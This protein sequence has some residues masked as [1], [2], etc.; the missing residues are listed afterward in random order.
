[1]LVLRPGRPSG[2]FVLFCRE[3]DPERETWDGRRAGTSDAVADFGADDAFPIT[4][5]D[6]ILPGMIEG[7]ERVYYSM[8]VHPDFD[9]RLIGWV[10]ALRDRG[11]SGGPA[12]DQFIAPGH[13]LHDLRLYKSRAEISCDA[14]SGEDRRPGA[15]ARDEQMPARHAGVR[16]GSRDTA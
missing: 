2:E 7:C 1:M 12:P 9:Q 14:Q 10:S 16:T 15:Q 6:E 8:G 11:S 3:R 13:M 5:I 4:D